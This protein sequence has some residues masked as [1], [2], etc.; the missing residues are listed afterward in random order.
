MFQEFKDFVSRGNVLDLAVAIVLG[1]A[2]VGLIGA[3]VDY[4]LL[5]IIGIIFGE[6]DFGGLLNFTVNDSTVALGDFI[7]EAIQFLILAFALFIVVKTFN[8]MRKPSDEPAAP[9]EVE[10]LTEIRDA[11]RG[12]GI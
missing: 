3:F 11:V 7:D 6:P 5:P 8:K 9:T 12:R 10:L 2:F 1:L 4:L